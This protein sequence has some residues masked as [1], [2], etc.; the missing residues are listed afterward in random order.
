ME[1]IYVAGGCLWGVEAFFS[2]I[3]GVISTEAGRANG[4]SLDL[5]GDY[6]GYVECVKVDFNQHKLTVFDVI[7]YL[8]E[9]IDPYSINRQGN[10][11]GRKYRTGIYSLVN[12]HLIEARQFINQRQDRERI[13]VEV[14]PLSN[15]VKSS[16]EHQ[17]HLKKCPEDIVMCHIHPELL[18]KYRYGD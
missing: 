3:P 8:F 14:L 12:Q 16:E 11:V 6:D 9:I 17:Q 2:T 4:S 5:Q 7:T 10:D 13:A 1:T 15:Y 18:Y